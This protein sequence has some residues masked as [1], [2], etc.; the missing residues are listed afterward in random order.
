[1]FRMARL[2]TWEGT[3]TF[4]H[5]PRDCQTLQRWGQ[6]K[7]PPRE[8]DSVKRDNGILFNV[9]AD[10]RDTVWVK[11]VECQIQEGDVGDFWLVDSATIVSNGKRTEPKDYLRIQK[12]GDYENPSGEWNRVEVI[13]DHGNIRFLVNGKEVNRGNDPL[14]SEGRIIIQ[15]EGAEIFYRKIEIRELK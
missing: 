6:K 13:S 1:M 7:W 3:R 12:T 11:S 5:P 10:I 9:P 8:A 4:F 2:K 15:S 14:P